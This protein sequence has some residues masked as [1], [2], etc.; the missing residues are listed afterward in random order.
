MRSE[1]VSM[2]FLHLR[3]WFH[4]DEPSRDTSEPLPAPGVAPV[5]SGGY[6]A[7]QPLR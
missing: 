4:L 3:L 6:I 5:A 2:A 7:P 1:I